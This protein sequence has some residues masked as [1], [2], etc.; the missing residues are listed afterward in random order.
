[1]LSSSCLQNGDYSDLLLDV[2]IENIENSI[3]HFVEV[4]WE[5]KQALF[6]SSRCK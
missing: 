2:N 6:I 4:L 5:L 1:M 3:K